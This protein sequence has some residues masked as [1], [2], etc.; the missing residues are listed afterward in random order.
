M[1][2]S[3]FRAI[4]HRVSKFLSEY[5]KVLLAIL[6]VVIVI[7]GTVWYRSFSKTQNGQPASGGTYIEGIVGGKEEAQAI[8]AKITK[9]GLFTFNSNGD[10]QNLLVSSYT[11]SADKSV[12]DFTL[13]PDIN[14]DEIKNALIE[15]SDYFSN[16]AVTLNGNVL[17]MTLSEPNP[18]IPLLL[19]EPI[20]DYGPFTLSKLS[21][22][23]TILT[24]NTRAHATNAYL[25][26]IVIMSYKTE[27]E[28]KQALTKGKVDGAT[29]H[30]SSFKT[31]GYTNQ[32][33]LFPEYFVLMFNQN[34]VPFK[35]V[36]YRQKI[37]ATDGTAK[38]PFTLTVANQEPYLTIANNLVA[39]WKAAGIPVALDAKDINEIQHSIAPS[40]NFQ[41]ILTG[42]NYGGEY[43]P[44]Y[45]WSSTQI[46]PTGNNLSGTK[47]DQI[48][49]LIAQIQ[50]NTNILKRQ[51]LIKELHQLLTS[52]GVATVLSQ[53]KG[54]VIMSENI[55]FVQPLTAMNTMDKWLSVGSWWVK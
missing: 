9:A 52:Q 8:A 39:S 24:R 14:G 7:T 19:T 20:F 54:V 40:R 44:Y 50:Q 32:D 35:D 42:I 29:L 46:R 4:G 2:K 27:D 6:S 13:L 21:D 26:K 11:V 36:K 37:L 41:A 15:N 17:K 43:D 18:D 33:I 3:S 55:S 25:N 10:L 49:A 31:S 51:A 23:T 38:T 30:D 28:L 22:T 5:E 1:F 53:E 34:V 47:N 16:A 45:I 48:D 12:Y